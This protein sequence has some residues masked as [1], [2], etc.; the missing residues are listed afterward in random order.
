MTTSW[1]RTC[2]APKATGKGYW[3]ALAAAAGVMDPLKVVAD[4]VDVH[5][6]GEQVAGQDHVLDHL[7]DLP[8]AD[9][10]GIAGAEGKVLQRSL[11]RHRRRRHRCPA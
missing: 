5:Q 4:G 2:G 1:I 10:V 9:H 6:R 11:R 8:V 3:P 7:G